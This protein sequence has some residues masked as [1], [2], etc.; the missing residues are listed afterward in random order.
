MK[1]FIEVIL[2]IKYL[3]TL[4]TWIISID[5]EKSSDKSLLSFIIK[6][7]HKIEIDCISFT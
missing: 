1:E 4:N 3:M 5:A 2:Y 6:T 7:L